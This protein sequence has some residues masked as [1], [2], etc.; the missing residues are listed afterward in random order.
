MEARPEKQFAHEEGRHHLGWGEG[1]GVEVGTQVEASYVRARAG[2]EKGTGVRGRW[3]EKR[4]HSGRLRIER[5]AITW[6]VPRDRA[7]SHHA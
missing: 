7:L 4:D 3:G 6:V 5:V 1:G 2:T